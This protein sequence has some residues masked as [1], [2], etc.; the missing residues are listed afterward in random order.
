MMMATEHHLRTVQAE[1]AEHRRE[2]ALAKQVASTQLLRR[3]MVASGIRF[4][5]LRLADAVRR[6]APRKAFT[7]ATS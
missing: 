4:G 3:L 5:G 7:P 2:I 1:A 6:P